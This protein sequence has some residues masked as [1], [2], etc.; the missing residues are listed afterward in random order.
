[1]IRV[2]RLAPDVLLQ[3]GPGTLPLA[4]ISA[5]TER[6]L[7]GVIQKMKQRLDPRKQRAR[8]ERLWVA[9]YVLMGL[10]YEQALVD[11]LLQGVLSMNESVTYQAI[12]RE[13][14]DEGRQKERAEVVT[15]ARTTLL[16]QG[17]QRF[18]TPP[19]RAVQA[20]LDAINDWGQLL[21]LLFAAITR[22]IDDRFASIRGNKGHGWF[23]ARSGHSAA[24]RCNV[25]WAWSLS[26][27]RSPA[28]STRASSSSRSA[29][30]SRSLFSDSHSNRRSRAGGS[31]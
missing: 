23:A 24:N 8:V 31:R 5:V 21:H 14:L 18:G 17:Q 6:E 19:P 20:A 13:G 25:A 26:T 4:P 9:T 28:K 29:L 15:T 30:V 2:W 16:D 11:R 3:G 1:M 12:L 22:A 7:P 27:V 10:R